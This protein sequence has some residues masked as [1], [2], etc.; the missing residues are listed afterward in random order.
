MTNVLLKLKAVSP[1]QR[2]VD[3]FESPFAAQPDPLGLV[4]TRSKS[5]KCRG[6]RTDAVSCF[7]FLFSI[8]KQQFF[9]PFRAQL[10]AAVMD[11]ASNLTAAAFPSSHHPVRRFLLRRA[12]LPIQNKNQLDVPIKKITVF[13]LLSSQS[14]VRARR[15]DAIYPFLHNPEHHLELASKNNSKLQR[16]RETFQF[17]FHF[18]HRH[19]VFMFYPPLFNLPDQ[20]ILQF[21]LPRLIWRRRLLIKLLTVGSKVHLRFLASFWWSHVKNSFHDFFLSIQNSW[22]LSPEGTEE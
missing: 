21:S 12:W 8:G 20:N 10:A 22:A 11:R 3:G 7:L 2:W 1:V 16:Q 17:L 4:S 18:A 6:N 5:H 9:Y 19:T 14:C 13:L 15:E